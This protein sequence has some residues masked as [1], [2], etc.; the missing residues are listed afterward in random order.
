MSERSTP[1]PC[2][3]CGEAQNV[4]PGG[5]DPEAEPFGP[6]TCMVCGHEFTRDE[7]IFT[8]FLIWY[9]VQEVLGIFLRPWPWFI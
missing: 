9:L 8:A 7:Y 2:P 4:I 1:V 6:V 5:F 3:N